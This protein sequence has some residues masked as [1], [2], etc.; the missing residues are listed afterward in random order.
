MQV[1]PVMEREKILFE[2]TRKWLRVMLAGKIIADSRKVYLLLPGGPPFYYFPQSDVCMDMLKP[3][4]RT[5]ESTRF[6]KAV[7]WDIKIGEELIENAA[8]TYPQ[9][10]APGIDLSGYVSFDWNKMEAW[11]E[12]NEQVYVHP[13][14][15]HKR[16]DILN[17]TRHIEVVVGG[18]KVAVSDRPTLLFETGLPTRY[19]LP[20]LDVRMDLLVPSDTVTG[21]AYKGKANYYSVKIGDKIFPDI[22]WYYRYPMM[23]A[24]KI[25]GLLCFYNER[26]DKLSVDGEEQTKPVTEWSDSR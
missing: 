12:E 19:Y 25:A 16:I 8:W 10:L 17:S 24:A 13:H 14:D 26:V 23:E 7:Y 1:H 4:D 18:Q 3:T 6:G 20:S 11:F 22:A 2:P 15:P 9:P 21:C 5:S